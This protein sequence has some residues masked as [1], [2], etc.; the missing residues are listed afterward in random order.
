MRKA[1]KE[2]LGFWIIGA[3]GESSGFWRKILYGLKERGPARVFLFTDEG[4]KGL[5]EEA[6]EV[7]SE[8][9]FQGRLLHKVRPPRAEQEERTVKLL[10]RI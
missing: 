8:A 4:L 2:V 1:I 7:Y 10:R 9:D 3:E 6:K 5:S